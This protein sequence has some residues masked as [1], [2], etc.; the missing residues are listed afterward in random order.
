MRR[1]DSPSPSRC[2]S[3]RDSPITAEM[4][5]VSTLTSWALVP[6]NNSPLALLHSTLGS[7]LCT[8]LFF[9]C[10]DLELPSLS[11]PLLPR[12]DVGFLHL[13]THWP[14]SS[15]VVPYLP[16][17]TF[18]PLLNHQDAPALLRRDVS[19][20]PEAWSEKQFKND[21]CQH[22]TSHVVGFSIIRMFVP[23]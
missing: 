12:V 15:F 10:W 11:P 9:L 7:S 1:M 17:L 19:T 8:L 18:S 22:H 21:Q 2:S 23:G 5:G 16:F 14:M 4:T 13:V 6:F 3:L 20:Y